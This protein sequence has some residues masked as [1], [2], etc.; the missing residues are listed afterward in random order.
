[1]SSTLQGKVTEGSTDAAPVPVMLYDYTGLISGQ[2]INNMQHYT[3]ETGS[4]KI[5]I[6]FGIK[7]GAQ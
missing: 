4:T 3:T 5:A 2:K 6:Y 1:M 7:T